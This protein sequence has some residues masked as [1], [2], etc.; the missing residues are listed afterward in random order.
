MLRKEY[1]ESNLDFKKRMLD[2]VSESF[3]G[4][5]WYN[6]SLYLH[7]GQNASCHLPPSHEIPIT[8]I[9]DK[10]AAIHNTPWKKEQRKMMLDGVRPPECEYC[11][12]I[13]DL[14]P[15]SVSDRVFKSIIYNDADLKRAAATPY[16]D[17]IAPKTVEVVFDR[18]C[19]F[20]CSYC[21]PEFST[22][23]TKDIK[24]NGPYKNLIA[25][26]GRIYENDGKNQDHLI[27]NNPYVDAFWAYWPEMVKGLEELRVTG[28]EPLMSTDVWKIIDLFAKEKY[29]ASLAI[30]S[31]LGA[32]PDLIEK[33]IDYSHKIPSLSLYTSMEAIGAEAEYIRDGLVFDEWVKNCEAVLERGNL[34]DFNIMCTVTSICLWSLTDLL[35]ITMEWKRKY[36]KQKGVFTLNIL[37]WPA[38]MSPLVLPN[39]IKDSRRAELE[40]WLE[41]NKDDPMLH[42]IER[43]NLTRLIDYLNY[44]KTPYTGAV[45]QQDLW[46]DM[47]SFYT[48]YDQRRD[49]KFNDTFNSELVE[50]FN[51]L[52]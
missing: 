19:N 24:V 47:K 25:R 46:K 43:D 21:A 41:K 32:K 35:D 52:P 50:W 29:S 8:L 26:E 31:N 27:G 6:V 42:N 40:R 13:E 30:N 2:P 11:W 15:T 37:R 3:C 16:S 34:R 5:K 4:A 45:S 14:G 10:A 17:D 28:G 7:I 49:K 33:L 18:T 1:K 20:A 22:S 12:K 9:K 51:R 38:W 23:W 48:Q 44:V 36:G 39:E